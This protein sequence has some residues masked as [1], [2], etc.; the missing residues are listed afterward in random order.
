M[1]KNSDYAQ[2][3]LGANIDDHQ[4]RNLVERRMQVDIMLEYESIMCR[5]SLEAGEAS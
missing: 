2:E 3:I 5:R 1:L 4:N